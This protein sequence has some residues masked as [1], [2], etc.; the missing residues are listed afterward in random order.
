MEREEMKKEWSDL[1][2]LV[3]L[4]VRLAL[5]LFVRVSVF[6]RGLGIVC[7]LRDRWQR[8]Q[9]RAG[10]GRRRRQRWRGAY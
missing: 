4:G 3:A 7:F 8:R 5:P 1:H 10:G 9:L 6:L 2:F